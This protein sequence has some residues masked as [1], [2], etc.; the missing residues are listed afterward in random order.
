MRLLQAVGLPRSAA[1]EPLRDH[2]RTIA[3]NS[4]ESAESRA[5]AIDFLALADATASVEWLRALVDPREP[6][7]V[8]AAAVRA[9]GKAPGPE[10]ATFLLSRWRSLTPPVRNEAADALL[11]DP[12]RTRALLAAMKAGEVQAWTLD[13][14]QKREIIMHADPEIRGLGRPLLESTPADRQAVVAR[15]E[16]AL[17]RGGDVARGKVVFIQVCAKCHRLDGTGAEMG[18]ELGTVRN[19][20]PEMLLADILMPNRSIAQKYE[21]YLVETTNGE[22]QAGVIAAETPT[23]VVLRREEGKESV[24]SR[25]DI[26]KISVSNLSAMPGDLENQIDPTQMR[27]LLAY[28]KGR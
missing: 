23:T 27:D 14:D 5:D 6:E 4:T 20:A 1:L 22:T 13:F 11:A 7:P 15:Y 19:R 24:I 2:V 12:A 18:P 26:R 10:T 9:L 8:Q 21:S 16:A 25:Q 3:S 17:D 28:L